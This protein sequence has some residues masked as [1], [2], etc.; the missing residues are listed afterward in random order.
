MQLNDYL[1]GVVAAQ[2][3]NV[4]IQA[5]K[6]QAVAARTAA[7][8]YYSKDKVI[9]DSSSSLQAFSA[10]RLET[11]KDKYPNAII[12]VK[13]TDG[14]LIAYN[15]SVITTC[16]YCHSNGGHQ[17]S[18]KEVWGGQRAWLINQIDPW[19]K[20]KKS[21]HGV[22]M[23]QM[24]AKR[25]ASLGKG[26]KEILAFYY[27]GTTIT[28]QKEEEQMATKVMARD[29][30]DA[31]QKIH[32]SYKVTYKNGMSGQKVGESY[33]CDCRGYVI[34]T[35]RSL[36]VSMTSTGTNWMIRNQMTNVFSVTNQS[37]LKPGMVVFKHY[38]KGNP[39]WNLPA[40]YRLGGTAYNKTFDQKDVYHVG[41]VVQT[42]PSLIIRHCSGGGIR[43]DTKL[44]AWDY[45]GYVQWVSPDNITPQ[46]TPVKPEPTP[47][48]PEVKDDD[49]GIVIA[50]K[51]NLRKAP[52]KSAARVEYMN[53]DDEVIVLKSSTGTS[54]WYYVKYGSK[55][56][57]VMS[58]FIKKKG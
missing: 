20:Q 7:Y 54:G 30:V 49:T 48:D 27:H 50:N 47:I 14:E 6:A 52:T 10:S 11:A 33:L 21:G 55:C 5:C 46:P 51:V 58:Q 3:G 24:G 29:F 53:K 39:K 43:T 25:A 34:W 41:I 18:S 12:A 2:V 23:S 28:K 31:A 36:G 57:Y 17:L 32:K 42:T 35:L 44:G 26:Y 22:G 56:G 1:I 16:S 8:P 13:D 40:K 37:Q 45:A 15:G 4:D 19:D 38:E 9:S